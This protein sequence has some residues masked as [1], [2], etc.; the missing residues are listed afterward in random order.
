MRRDPVESFARLKSRRMYTSMT[1][2]DI[3]V[4]GASAGGV[5]A[6][7]ELCRLLPANLPAAVF[8]VI[9]IGAYPSKLPDVLRA[10]GQLQAEH[11]RDGQRPAQG[12]IYLAPPDR[13]MLIE[14]GV[15]RITRG[16]KENHTRPA[17]D[18]LFRS[19][20]LSCGPRTLG[21][22]L[23]GHLD[24]GT[25]GMKAIKAC[26]G[27][28]LVQ[29]PREAEAVGMPMSVLQNLEVDHCLRLDGLA[30]ALAQLTTERAQPVTSRPPEWLLMEHLASLNEG[31]KVMEH[32]ESLGKPSSLV[33]PECTGTL[34]ELSD[35][36]PLRY[37]C[38]TGHAY[39]LQSL[40]YQQVMGSESALW[41]A[42][43]ALQ[44]RELVLRKLASYN[45]DHGNAALA[46]AQVLAAEQIAAHALQV[47]ELAEDEMESLQDTGL[48]GLN[49]D[50]RF[51]PYPPG[52]RT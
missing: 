48:P 21:V 41:S 43:R 11:A 24:D 47:Q 31:Q 16:P 12:H 42:V 19:A 6:L 9:H 51:E 33:C 5:N 20:A 40:A 49:D 52:Q 14:D 35:S 4:I 44:D 32:L 8:A 26:G 23:S 34:W 22:I 46:E 25:L 30:S 39:S 37:R 13:H 15:I 45:R 10:C 36:K 27:V 28:L 38:H 2:R 3:I 17:I 7:C 1:Q 50:A 29:D 18:P